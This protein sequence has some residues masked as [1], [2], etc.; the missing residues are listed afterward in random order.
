MVTSVSIITYRVISQSYET[1]PTTV[2]SD[3]IAYHVY[4]FIPRYMYG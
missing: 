4:V 2:F 1:L 3:D